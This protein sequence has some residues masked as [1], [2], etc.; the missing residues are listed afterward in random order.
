MIKP[1][2]KMIDLEQFVEFTAALAYLQALG[3]THTFYCANGRLQSLETGSVFPQEQFHLA[4]CQRF[5]YGVQNAQRMVLYAVESLDGVKGI[6][7]DDCQS[8][9]DSCLGDFLVRLKMSQ[10][11]RA[12]AYRLPQYGPAPVGAKQAS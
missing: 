12:S 2:S 8:Y 4:G 9:G 1:T 10:M 7:L 3:F 5:R 11:P 6:V